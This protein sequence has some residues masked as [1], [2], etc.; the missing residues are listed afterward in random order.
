MGCLS[1]GMGPNTVEAILEKY[2]TVAAL[3]AAY[4]H[5]AIRCVS[6]LAGKSVKQGES[7]SGM[8][9]GVPGCGM[10]CVRADSGSS[11]GVYGRVCKRTV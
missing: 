8:S 7:K 11:I 4:T 6:G 5:A 2:P 3:H 10:E 9:W 1:A